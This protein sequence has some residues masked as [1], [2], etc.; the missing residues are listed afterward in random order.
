VNWIENIVLHCAV[1]LTEIAV[2][3]PVVKCNIV[4]WI[5]N[6]VLHCA[7]LLIIIA[8]QQI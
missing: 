5:E 1:L 8:V 3:H 7:L 2:Q 4:N 6:I